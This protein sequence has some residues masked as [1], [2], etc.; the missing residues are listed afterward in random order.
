MTW[1]PAPNP[2]DLD[3]IG[4]LFEQHGDRVY[5]YCLRM[6]GCEHD[7]ADAPQDTFI[8]LARRGVGA[9]RD[10]DA[11]RFYLFAAARNACFDLQR[12]RRGDAS[13]DALRE[14]G[15]DLDRAPLEPRSTPEQRALDAA[16]R[17]AVFGA[18]ATRPRAP[19]HGVGA[20]RARRPHLRRARR[21]GSA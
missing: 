1:K 8:N 20:A 9:A 6:L 5:G 14:A 17:A 13:L 21:R 4:R 2:L 3:T 15:A 12:R 19:A 11:L 7:A 18:L 10:D 16:T